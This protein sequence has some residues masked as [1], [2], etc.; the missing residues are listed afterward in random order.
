MEI[1][2]TVDKA[3]VMTEVAKTTAYVAHKMDIAE[4]AA[5]PYGRIPTVD[6][7]TEM[8][9][10]FFSEAANGAADALKEW[11]AEVNEPRRSPVATLTDATA[12]DEL[13]YNLH[14]TGN[15]KTAVL[16]SMASSLFSYF[17]NAIC[18]KWFLMTNKAEAEAYTSMATAHMDD[19]TSKLYHRVRPTRPDDTPSAGLG[20]HL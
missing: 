6:E 16:S 12:T 7:D 14:L 4:D 13:A 17:V 19:V 2:L 18:A 1:R 10:R 8:L 15:F 3:K 11:L 20:M 5:D 9:D